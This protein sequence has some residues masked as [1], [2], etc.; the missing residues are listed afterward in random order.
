MRVNSLDWIVRKERFFFLSVATLTS[1]SITSCPPS[2]S[3]TICALDSTTMNLKRRKK[4][5]REERERRREEEKRKKRRRER[6][7]KTTKLERG[8]KERVSEFTSS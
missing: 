5:E 7:K 6:K 1:T 4:R 2:H 3:L 8:K